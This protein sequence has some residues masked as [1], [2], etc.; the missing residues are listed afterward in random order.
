ML[1]LWVRDQGLGFRVRV[2]R[3]R[4]RVRESVGCILTT[5]RTAE[6]EGK[7]KSPQ[8]PTQQARVD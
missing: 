4:V 6:K 1:G 2:T 5:V 7:I 3:V 8:Y